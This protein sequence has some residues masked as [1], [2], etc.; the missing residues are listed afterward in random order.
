MSLSPAASLT[1]VNHSF[2]PPSKFHIYIASYICLWLGLLWLI[3]GLCSSP[4]HELYSS[5]LL[6]LSLDGE[7]QCQVWE[8][9]LI[10]KFCFMICFPYSPPWE[11]TELV[12]GEHQ[13]MSGDNSKIDTWDLRL[14]LLDL[15]YTYKQNRDRLSLWSSRYGKQAVGT[16]NFHFKS[17]LLG[18][19]LSCSVGATRRISYAFQLNG[20]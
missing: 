8:D 18:N 16:G 10:S 12:S 11:R 9:L 15:P 19:A 4:A 1:E 2:F 14:F 6:H 20:I 7:K 3:P 5:T 17:R 13:K